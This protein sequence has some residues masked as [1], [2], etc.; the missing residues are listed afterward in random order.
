MSKVIPNH[1]VR[2]GQT[3]CVSSPEEH[4][5]FHPNGCSSCHTMPEQYFYYSMEGWNRQNS[6]P[7]TEGRSLLKT[8][9]YNSCKP[10]TEVTSTTSPTMG[11][12]CLQD[13]PAGMG[14]DVSPT[15]DISIENLN[16]LILEI[17]PT[18]QPLQL[19]PAQNQSLAQ[20]VSPSNTKQA[21]ESPGKMKNSSIQR[22]QSVESIRWQNGL[23]LGAGLCI[24]IHKCNYFSLLDP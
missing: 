7:Q 23:S 13:D 6:L 2:V 9:L 17:D 15:L 18:F 14:N 19:K 24:M 1:V 21:S 22:V 10:S 8:E 16:N 11:N 4:A 3:I 12:K 5:C 20:A